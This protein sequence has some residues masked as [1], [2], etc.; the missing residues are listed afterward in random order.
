MGRQLC[1]RTGRQ[2]YTQKHTIKERDRERKCLLN[3]NFYPRNVQVVIFIILVNK[4]CLI[5]LLRNKQTSLYEVGVSPCSQFLRCRK[6]TSGTKQVFSFYNQFQYPEMQRSHFSL[7][8]DT[9][10]RQ[11]PFFVTCDRGKTRIFYLIFCIKYF[12]RQYSL[13]AFVE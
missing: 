9:P 13:Q 10:S 5:S 4:D 11:Q 7:T 8:V 3:E 1:R 2:V 6:Y 12:L